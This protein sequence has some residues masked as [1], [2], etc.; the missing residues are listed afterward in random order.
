MATLRRIIV[1]FLVIISIT[2][3]GRRKKLAGC[4]STQTKI[5]KNRNVYVGATSNPKQ[6]RS[7]H[8]SSGYSGE[9]HY[10]ST[11]NMR[12]AEN[13]LLQNSGSK[14]NKQKKS[15]APTGPGYVYGIKGAR[16]RK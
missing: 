8:Q 2:I 11:N 5:R 15:N 3:G 1:T 16:K 4:P 14:Y 7:S 6:R 9:M 13:I 12:Q 10:A